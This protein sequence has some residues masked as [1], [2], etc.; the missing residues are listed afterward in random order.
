MMPFST[1]RFVTIKIVSRVSK[2]CT[3]DMIHNIYNRDDRNIA[4]TL[5]PIN[6]IYKKH[7]ILDVINIRAN[8]LYMLHTLD[9]VNIRVSI[10]IRCNKI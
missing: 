3:L 10:N 9:T 6:I 2:K 1:I 8:K 7:C 4:Y 5:D